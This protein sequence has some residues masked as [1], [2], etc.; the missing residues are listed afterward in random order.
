MG[1]VARFDGLF[2]AAGT[3]LTANQLWGANSGA[4]AMEGKTLTNGAGVTV[5]HGTGTITFGLSDLTPTGNITLALTKKLNVTTGTN[6]SA[7]T[8]T[9]V[10]GTVTVSTTAVTS[11]SLIYVVYDTPA[12]TL[13]SGLSAPAGSIVNATSFVINSVT[14][15]GVVNTTDTST[16]RWWIIN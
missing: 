7:G 12:G 16:V 5:T 8:A 10:L 11:S 1:G 13:A 4:T 9:L 15:A 6:A 2:N 14:T 3:A